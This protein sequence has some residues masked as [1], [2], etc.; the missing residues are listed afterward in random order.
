LKDKYVTYANPEWQVAFPSGV[1]PSASVG[2]ALYPAVSGMKGV[3]LRCNFGLNNQLPLLRPPE[4]MLE[5]P[6]EQ[7]R[8]HAAVL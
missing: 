3:K 8:W 2:A 4:W 6:E 7:V 5:D 1:Q